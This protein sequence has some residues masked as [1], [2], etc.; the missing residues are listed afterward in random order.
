MSCFVGRTQELALLHARLE[1]AIGGQG[2]VIGITGEPGLGKSRLLAEFAHRLDGQAVTYC[3]GYCLA[4]DST[5]P[6]LPV[7]ALLQQLWGLPDTAAPE[8]ITATIRQRLRVAGVTSEDE[9]LLLSQLF[10]VPGELAP[11]A[12]LSPEMRIAQTFALL[13][14]VIRHASQRQPLVLA[15]ENLH[16]SDPTSEEWLASLINQL[17]DTP[18]LILATYRPGYQPPWLRHSAATQMALPRLS[19]SDSLADYD[20][21]IAS[22]ERALAIAEALGDVGLQVATRCHLGH[23]YYFTNAYRR[24]VDILRKNRASLQ[25]ELLHERFG[26]H[27]PAS[28]FSRTWLIVSLAELGAFAEAAT[29]AEEE[30]RIAESV[31]QP[32]SFVHVSFSTGLLY[33][34]QGALHKA[35]PAL[36]RGLGL[37]QVWN[38]QRLCLSWSKP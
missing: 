27:V 26:M 10:D 12:A 15:V 28:V 14:H 17:A 18:V 32:A 4:Y 20:R 13:R 22:G 29:C 6:Y 33:C 35:M 3:E 7:R 21:A 37:C 19:R 25:G 16:W 9:V 2:Q 36:E 1:Q 31:D 11:V 8:A 5:T 30:V 23:A 38:M 34:R 24:A